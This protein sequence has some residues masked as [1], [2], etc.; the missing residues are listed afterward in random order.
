MSEPGVKYLWSD[1]PSAHLN[2]GLLS[3]L[4]TYPFGYVLQLQKALG[5]LGFKIK[6]GEEM[7]SSRMYILKPFLLF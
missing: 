7:A 5:Q 4:E 3:C 2:R 6:S 1:V